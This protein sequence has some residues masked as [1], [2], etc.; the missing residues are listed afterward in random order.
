MTKEVLRNT[1]RLQ[2]IA[3]DLNLLGAHGS[4]GESHPSVYLSP[5]SQRDKA[6][7]LY[8]GEA[9]IEQLAEWL[10]KHSDNKFKMT[11]KNL[12]QKLQML[13]MA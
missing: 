4:L 10:K 6:P 2:F 1:K 7:K 9:R 5:G 13:Q 3:Y 11:T 12:D 8:R